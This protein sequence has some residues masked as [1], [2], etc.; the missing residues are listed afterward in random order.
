MRA[1]VV[2]PEISG[3][4]AVKSVPVPEP[5]PSEALVRVAA[6]SLNLGEV[7]RTRSAEAGW[8]PGWDVAG[9]VE[10]TAEDGSGPPAGTRVV[11][12]LPNAGWSE[13]AA[14]PTNALA[15]LPHGVEF[16]AASTLP[17]A[18]LTALYGL[19]KSGS[20][21]ERKV[22]ITGASGG[23]GH[24]ACQIARRAGARVIGLVRHPDREQLVRSAGAHEV[25]IS[26][27]PSAAAKFG[28]YNLV[29]ESVGGS[30]FGSSIKVLGPEGVCVVYGTSGGNDVRFDAA[31]FFLT[32][33]ASIYGFILFHELRYDPASNG[34]ARLLKM[35]QSGT[36]KPHIETEASWNDIAAVTA[37]LL[38][39]RV[40][41]K[42][43]LTVD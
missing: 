5:K 19:E 32:G 26:D 35:L 23:V 1:V 7:R 38:E 29:L 31:D 28:P 40:P 34:L 37:D 9:T 39:R 16:G 25:V 6:F 12:L 20:I 11:G 21:M 2:D 17:V 33:G 24:F 43:V 4:L 15:P 14:V 13:Y 41:G 8:R 10:R 36:I 30:T 42:A 27:D 22:L 3:R 18:G